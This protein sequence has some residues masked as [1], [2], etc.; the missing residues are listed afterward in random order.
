MTPFRSSVTE[1]YANVM[2]PIGTYAE[3][4]GSFVNGEGRWQLFEGV[5]AAKGETRP[6]WKVLR[7]MGNLLG[8]DGFDYISVEDVHDEAVAQIGELSNATG[9]CVFAK[10]L[11]TESATFERIADLPMYATDG[12]IRR[13]DAL[14]N[15]ADA[16]T[17]SVYLSKQTAGQL[18]VTDGDVLDVQQGEGGISLPVIIDAR[19]PEGAAYI[20]ASLNGTIGLG[21]AQSSLN[22]AKASGVATDEKVSAGNA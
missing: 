19:V 11:S 7:V 12:I 13:A 4:A 5:C 10:S 6:A 21:N 15:T 3:T 14:Q 20:P 22:I 17:A 1:T 9:Q 2:L 16:L 18:A 8:L